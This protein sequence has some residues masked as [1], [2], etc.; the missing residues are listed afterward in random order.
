MWFYT[1]PK[2]VRF[3]VFKGNSS[4]FE[5]FGKRMKGGTRGVNIPC[6]SYDFSSRGFSC[7]HTLK[8]EGFVGGRS[9]RIGMEEDGVMVAIKGR[10]VKNR[11]MGEQCAPISI[12]K[13]SVEP[14]SNI[15]SPTSLIVLGKRGTREANIN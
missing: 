13:T 9:V 15:G 4:V 2:Q 14:F 3:Q 7:P 12:N 6:L 5:F 10:E 1:L 11:G 8:T